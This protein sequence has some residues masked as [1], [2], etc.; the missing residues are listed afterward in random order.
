MKTL[1]PKI[2]LQEE[3]QKILNWRIPFQTI[4]ESGIAITTEDG[5]TLTTESSE[6]LVTE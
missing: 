4:T 5:I 3:T 6:T 1:Y 2:S